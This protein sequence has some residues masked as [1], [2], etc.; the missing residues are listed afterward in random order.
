MQDRLASFE[1]EKSRVAEND[2]VSKEFASE[3]GPLVTEVNDS[4]FTLLEAKK[5][6]EDQLSHVAERLS[7]VSGTAST[8]LAKIEG[9][10]VQLQSRMVMFNEYTTLAVS[11][12]R[13]QFSFFKTFLEN[14][15]PALE[16][17]IEHKLHKGVSKEQVTEITAI[18]TEYD[19]DK[20]GSID[21]KELRAALF[22]LGEEASKE[23]LDG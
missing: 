9:V 10:A 15:K 22:S 12:V 14:K 5:D 19:K 20:S 18:Y 21:K 7:W 16:A 17:D 4:M 2:R 1:R 23:A 3:A 8:T 6:L 13:L 11:D